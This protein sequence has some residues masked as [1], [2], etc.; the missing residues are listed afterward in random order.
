MT[1]LTHTHQLKTSSKRETVNQMK[2]ILPTLNL[3]F[4]YKAQIKRNIKIN[5][6]PKRNANNWFNEK[7][8][9]GNYNNLTNII[10]AWAKS[11]ISWSLHSA[12]SAFYIDQLWHKHVASINRRQMKMLICNNSTNDV[13]NRRHKLSTIACYVIC[14]HTFVNGKRR[15]RRRTVSL[16]HSHCQQ[17]FS[18][19]YSFLSLKPR[20]YG[21]KMILYLLWSRHNTTKTVVCNCSNR[22][23]SISTSICLWSVFFSFKVLHI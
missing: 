9:N 17:I 13:L 2:E 14:I 22:K 16:C 15:G 5:I 19:A 12:V 3:A 10:V 20:E 6:T 21:A 8:P 4:T 23:C 11:F 1:N 7:N 18:D